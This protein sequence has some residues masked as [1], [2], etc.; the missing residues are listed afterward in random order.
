MTDTTA[1]I[2][3]RRRKAERRDSIQYWIIYAI[4]FAVFLI[5]ESVMRLAAALRL[6]RRDRINRK[7]IINE[8]RASAG[9]TIPYA[10]MG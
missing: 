2:A 4:G 10:F 3:S 5:A 8:A 9:A 6:V 7:S 1:T